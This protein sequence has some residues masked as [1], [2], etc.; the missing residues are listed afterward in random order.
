MTSPI[1]A[2]IRA[3][4]RL[5]A[6]ASTTPATGHLDRRAIGDAEG[7]RIVA[8]GAAQVIEDALDAVATLRR[9]FPDLELDVVGGG[10]WGDRLRGT[11]DAAGDSSGHLPWTR[12]GF[13]ETRCL[14]RSWVRAAPSRKEGWESPWSRRPRQVPTHWVQVV[15]RAYRFGGRWVT[16]I[17]VDDFDGLVDRLAELLSDKVLRDELGAMGAGAQQEN[18]WRRVVASMSTVLRGR[19][20]RQSRQWW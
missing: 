15:G 17:L 13:D 19:P 6:T 11:G 2:V 3:R 12:R 4:S 1:S 14:Q 9:R 8:S 7:R 18:S 5:C 16:G 10:W 20:R